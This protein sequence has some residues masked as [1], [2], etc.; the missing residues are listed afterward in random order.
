MTSRRVRLPALLLTLGMV[1]QPF[2]VSAQEVISPTVDTA[3]LMTGATLANVAG[4]F[5]AVGSG[6]GVA[7]EMPNQRWAIAG[8]VV[9]GAQITFGA[10]SIAGAVAY[11]RGALVATYGAATALMGAGNL[12]LGLI[13]LFKSHR[14]Q[15]QIDLLDAPAFS[16]APT[17]LGNGGFGVSLTIG[18]SRNNG[19]WPEATIIE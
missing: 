13:N 19:A 8:T 17:D 10:L 1:V 15:R 7:Y 16:L 2:E 6:I 4:M 5:P 14:A 18:P 11:K 9:G 3:I 12:I